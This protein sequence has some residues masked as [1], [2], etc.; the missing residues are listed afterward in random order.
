MSSRLQHKVVFRELVENKIN[1][2]SNFILHVEWHIKKKIINFTKVAFADSDKFYLLAVQNI[3]FL[4]QQLLKRHFFLE[5][6]FF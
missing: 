1:N 3:L 6:T 5:H 2:K 4:Y